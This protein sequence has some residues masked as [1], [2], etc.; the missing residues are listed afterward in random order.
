METPVVG[1][2][3]G[4]VE[5]LVVSVVLT[6]VMLLSPVVLKLWLVQA[7]AENAEVRNNFNEFG[8]T[9]KVHMSIFYFINATFYLKNNVEINYS[10]FNKGIVSLTC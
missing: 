9:F 7:V 8:L 1:D 6:D 2:M 10:Y 5:L 3:M 4:G